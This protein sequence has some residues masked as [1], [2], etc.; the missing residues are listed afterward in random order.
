[1]KDFIGN[2]IRR[3]VLIP[4]TYEGIDILALIEVG[5]A[6]T[7]KELTYLN[8]FNKGAKLV[9]EDII[10]EIKSRGG[11]DKTFKDMMADAKKKLS[12]KGV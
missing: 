12:K 6:L 7:N 2:T 11:S 1:M 9:Q 8:F 4:K 5:G 3:T 10:N